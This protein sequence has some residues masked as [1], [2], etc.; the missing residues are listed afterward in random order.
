MARRKI[1]PIFI[2]QAGCK[3]KCIFCNQKGITGVNKIPNKDELLA[4]MPQGG[5]D[6]EL[7]Y[8]GG[9]FTA[10]PIKTMVAYLDFAQKMREEGR[11]GKIR[12]STH[13]S[14]LNDE[15][16]AILKDYG[17]NSVELGIQSM[18]DE[19]LIKA[20]RGHTK[21]EILYSMFLVKN[22]GFDLGVQLMTGLPYETP[23]KIFSGIEEILPYA[24][25]MVRIYPLL[26]LQDTPLALE[27]VAGKY[28]PMS[29][30]AAVSLVRD[31]YA[32]FSYYKIPVIRMGLQPTVD[33]NIHSDLLLDGP[34]HPSFGHLVKS[35]LKLKQIEMVLRDAPDGVR[36]ITAKKDLPQV[37]GLNGEN[38]SKIAEHHHIAVSGTGDLQGTV[39]LAPFD[40]SKRSEI[41]A[42]LGESE[43]LKKYLNENEFWSKQ[44]I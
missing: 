17:V 13:P 31:M 20:G 21:R 37:Y 7:A 2:P 29:L 38:I 42:S 10:L 15:K 6:Y 22:N 24:P 16:I 28:K 44:C 39:S 19:V 40:K 33:L 23:K 14:S 27:Y 18:D 8:Y 5:C 35:A 34:F 3:N 43:F 32:V 41:I 4:L 11:I 12:L 25:N 36:I 1:I 9:S 26:V 30:N